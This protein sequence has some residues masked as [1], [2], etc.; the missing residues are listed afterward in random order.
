MAKYKNYSKPPTRFVINTLET[1]VMRTVH[2]KMVEK[3]GKRK[4]KQC[5]EPEIKGQTIYI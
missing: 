1:N 2:Q 5:V 3:C 4:S